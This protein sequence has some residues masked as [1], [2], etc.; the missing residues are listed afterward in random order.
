MASA[1]AA[2]PDIVEGHIGRASALV[3]LGRD[4]EA[5]AALRA[6]IERVALEDRPKVL[7]A[8]KMQ[9]ALRESLLLHGRNDAVGARA[10]L[11]QTDAEVGEVVIG[12]ASSYHILARTFTSATGTHGRPPASATHLGALTTGW[13]GA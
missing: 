3:E 13:P 4:E 7:R 10:R 1:I 6:L 9:L 8:L 12:G 5:I 11:I 2:S